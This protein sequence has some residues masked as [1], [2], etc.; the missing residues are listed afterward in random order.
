MDN[1]VTAE[2]VEGKA[3]P[4]VNSL[5]KRFEG[6]RLFEDI[7]KGSGTLFGRNDPAAELRGKQHSAWK[8]YIRL[9]GSRYERCGFGNYEVSTKEQQAAVDKLSAMAGSNDLRNAILLGPAGTVKDHLLSAAVRIAIKSGCFSVGW[10][11][12]PGLFSKLRNAISDKIK[13]DDVLLPYCKC[14]LLV[15][16]DLA[17]TKLTD[18]QREIVYKIIDRRYN[19]ALITWVSSNIA[20]R[21][22]FQAVTSSQIVDRLID[23]AVYIPCNWS[24]YRKVKQ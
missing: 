19:N 7:G 14:R 11:S 10:T 16:S 3:Q 22:A 8:G 5:L 4:D 1:Q 24:S 17:M 20:S 2:A 23:D 12:G 9:R 18:Y 6:D 13:E 15:I 21:E